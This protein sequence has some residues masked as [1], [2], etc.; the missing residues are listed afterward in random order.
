MSFI[1]PAFNSESSL[2]A[3]LHS[4]MAQVTKYPFEI[5]VVDD[6]STD[7]TREIVLKFAAK[8][9]TLKRSGPAAARNAGIAAAR[10]EYLAFIDADVVLSP[11]WMEVALGAMNLPWIDVL[12]GPNVPTGNNP[13]S[14]MVRYRKH[15]ISLQTLG[16]FNYLTLS[17]K[18]LPLIN[19]AA[20]VIRAGVFHKKNIRFRP[21]FLRCEDTD[22]SLQLFHSGAHFRSHSGLRSQVYDHRRPLQY[23]V[24]SF[25]TGRYLKRVSDQWGIPL[26]GQPSQKFS[27]DIFLM[28]FEFF[29]RLASRLGEISAGT[30]RINQAPEFTPMKFNDFI[31]PRS[32]GTLSPFARMVIQDEQTVLFSCAPKRKSILRGEAHQVFQEIC[33]GK[34]SELTAQEKNLFSELFENKILIPIG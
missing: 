8:T 28:I 10:G 14:F 33:V 4:L 13:E 7:R 18:S 34:K 20:V 31:L 17:E 25:R 16:T 19:T 6:G 12:Q 24:R 29:N 15:R 3:C 27:D 2:E 32:L 30:S 11:D 21:E 26:S 23:L 5:I 1:I 9:L 22:L